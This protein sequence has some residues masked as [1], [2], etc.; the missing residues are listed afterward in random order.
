M[1]EVF[2]KHFTPIEA[3]KRLPLVRQIVED[4]LI[5]GQQLRQ[6]IQNSPAGTGISNEGLEI[7]SQIQEHLQELED[8]GCYFKD[9]TLDIG[10]VDFPAFIEGQP[11][12]L[13]WRSD[14]EDIRYF[15]SVNETYNSRKA[16]PNHLLN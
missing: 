10:L 7:Q 3:K 2:K 9:W 4:I 12:Y 1:T 15:H 8:L 13:C 16:I 14:E 5:K 6:I 11:V